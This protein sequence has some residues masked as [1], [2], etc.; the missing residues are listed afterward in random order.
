MRIRT[1]RA[2]DWH[3]Q[4]NIGTDAALALGVMHILARDG[5]VDR[6]YIAAHTVGFDRLEAQVL[7]R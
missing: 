1:A 3:L 5:R 6:D 4:I 2:A 7:P